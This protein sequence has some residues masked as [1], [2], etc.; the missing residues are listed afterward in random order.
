MNKLK[1]NRRTG[2]NQ[3]KYKIKKD[4]REKE[5]NTYNQK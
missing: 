4:N 1:F 5:N 2:R 3:N